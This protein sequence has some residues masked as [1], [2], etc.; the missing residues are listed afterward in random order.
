MHGQLLR[1][2]VFAHLTRALELFS[3]PS[4]EVPSIA[5]PRLWTNELIRL[6][7]LP[8]LGARLSMRSDSA[9]A[10]PGLLSHLANDL[11]LACSL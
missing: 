4:D 6:E 5:A 9:G 10:P 2:N 3:L 7:P 8:R 11:L 1:L